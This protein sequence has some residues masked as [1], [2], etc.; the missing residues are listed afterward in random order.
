[1]RAGLLYPLRLLQPRPPPLSFNHPLPRTHRPPFY[2]DEHRST[3]DLEQ[4]GR[5]VTKLPPFYGILSL[6]ERAV[7]RFFFVLDFSFPATR[8]HYGPPRFPTGGARADS[9][10]RQPIAR[11][12]GGVSFRSNPNEPSVSF[13]RT[14]A[15]I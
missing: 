12:T 13:P 1:M 7:G 11:N 6:Q 10:Q 4:S 2:V 15:E 5:Q 8:R 14:P 9:Q 3:P